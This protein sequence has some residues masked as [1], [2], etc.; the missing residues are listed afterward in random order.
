MKWTF[1]LTIV[2]G[3]YADKVPF[4]CDCAYVRFWQ[5]V[6]C[7]TRLAFIGFIHCH[8]ELSEMAAKF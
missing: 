4:R 6:R 5:F 2:Y 1:T 7:Y 3:R 8:N